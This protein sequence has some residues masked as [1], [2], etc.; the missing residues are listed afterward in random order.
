MTAE[1][2]LLNRSALALAADSAV[3]IRSGPSVKIYD[4][5]EKIFELSRRQPIALMIYNNVDHVGI[6]LDVLIRKYRKECN[7][8]FNTINEA[9]D[10]FL[11]YL[12]NYDHRIDEEKRYLRGM[13]ITEFDII[14]RELFNALGGSAK[15]IRKFN[16][17]VEIS[18]ILDTRIAR[19][20]S[21]VMEGYLDEVTVG[22]FI[23]EFGVVVDETFNNQMPF[24]T[25]DTIKSKAR[26]LAFS[27]VKCSEPS[28]NQ[29]GLVFGGFEKMICFLRFTRSK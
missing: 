26:E 17:L 20:N 16:P 2:A 29:T 1:V 22:N 12:E 21:R 27:L 25:D 10:D 11:S 15:K 28:G 14:S 13:L 19:A 24:K 18:R 8:E 6:P 5:A 7:K 9:A 23:D 4:S 3:T